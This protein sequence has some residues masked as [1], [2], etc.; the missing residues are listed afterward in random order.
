MFCCFS[1]HVY[2][3]V[4]TGNQGAGQ[5]LARIGAYRVVQ[6][7]NVEGL[8]DAVR[9]YVHDFVLLLGFRFVWHGI[10]KYQGI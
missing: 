6:T 1:L 7:L 3:A 5:D 2:C 4:Q 8:R 9:T 10:E